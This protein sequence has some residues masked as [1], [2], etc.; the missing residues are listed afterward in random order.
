VLSL[1]DRLAPDLVLLDLEIPGMSGLVCLDRIVAKHPQTKVVVWSERAD[2]ER[3]EVAF[4]HGACGYVVKSIDVADL[5]SAI[6]QAVQATA[7][8]AL[9]LPAMRPETAAALG[10]TARELSIVQA[11]ARGR[12]NQA[13]GKQLFVTEQTIKL[14]MTNI[15]RKRP[16]E[17]NGLHAGLRARSLRRRDRQRMAPGVPANRPMS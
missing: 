4:K 12:S 16:R 1:V 11:V 10:L 6:R 2:P 3:I 17:P 15:L 14:H 5:A 8:H 7:Y 13:I 9:G